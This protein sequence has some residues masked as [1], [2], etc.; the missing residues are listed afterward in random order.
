MTHFHTRLACFVIFV[1]RFVVTY[2]DHGSVWITLVNR[3]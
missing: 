1:S 2:K 3:C